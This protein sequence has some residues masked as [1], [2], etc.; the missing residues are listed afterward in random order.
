MMEAQDDSTKYQKIVAC[1][2][3]HLVNLFVKKLVYDSRANPDQDTIED[4]LEGSG[5]RIVRL[6]EGYFDPL[7]EIIFQN[8]PLDIMRRNFQNAVEWWTF[9]AEFQT[10]EQL[11][12]FF[13]NSFGH[14]MTVLS[15]NGQSKSHNFMAVYGFIFRSSSAPMYQDF[16]E[17]M[18]NRGMSG[19]YISCT[20]HQGALEGDYGDTKKHF[21]FIINETSLIN[22][23]VS[24]YF[25]EVLV[26]DE[27]SP[28][29]SLCGE[30][31]VRG[32]RGWILNT[33]VVV[34]ESLNP[35][36]YGKG[37]PTNKSVHPFTFRFFPSSQLMVLCRHM[38]AL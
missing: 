19:L 20:G 22:D 34:N 35:V 14:D 5:Y 38:S 32:I 6:Q 37:D 24:Q 16:A 15:R 18:T 31:E 7:N 26:P 33:C 12:S 4:A 36:L 30:V 13:R 1:M 11:F 29:Q 21:C 23:T 8:I 25:F 3:L 17:L 2:K 10:T 28:L 27:N 9:K